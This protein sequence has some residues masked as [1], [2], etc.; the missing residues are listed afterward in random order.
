V[1]AIVVDAAGGNCN[2]DEGRKQHEMFLDGGEKGT[3]F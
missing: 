1:I 2:D 3:L